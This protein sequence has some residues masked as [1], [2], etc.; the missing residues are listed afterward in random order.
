M[1]FEDKETKTTTGMPLKQQ[2]L[3]LE[4]TVAGVSDEIMVHYG[5][6]PKKLAQ[7]FI[8]KHSLKPSSVDKITKHIE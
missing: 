1:S 8:N 5:D 4:I 2:L 7:D 3:V 6:F